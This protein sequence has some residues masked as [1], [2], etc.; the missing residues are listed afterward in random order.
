[1]IFDTTTR[2]IYFQGEKLTSDDVPSQTTIVDIMNILIDRMGED[3]KNDGFPLSSYMKNKNE[4]LGKIV[5]PL[6]RFLETKT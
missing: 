6:I 5:I 2:K 3:V 4:M 1:M